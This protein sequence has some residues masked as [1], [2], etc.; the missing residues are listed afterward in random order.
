M[1][2]QELLEL[3]EGEFKNQMGFEI[4]DIESILTNQ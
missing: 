2:K 4:S 1:Q 3:F